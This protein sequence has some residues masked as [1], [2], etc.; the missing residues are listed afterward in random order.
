[1]HYVAIVE[2]G[3]AGYG[4]L[5]PELN[6]SATGKTAE[7]VRERLSQGIALAVLERRHR[8]LP[9]PPAVYQS[10]ADLPLDLQEDFA[11]AETV[12]LS[13]APINPVSV[14]IE[15][16]V[17]ASG[18][19]DSEIAR[20]IGSSPAGVARLQDYFYWGHSLATLRKLADA[21]SLQVEFKLK[22]A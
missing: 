16:A 2:S 22:V 10:F 6:V 9:V 15:R 17:E 14:E 3:A 5:V 19:S 21:L 1:M 8:N 20:R 18:L 4:G 11:G 13:P 12:Q 7:Q